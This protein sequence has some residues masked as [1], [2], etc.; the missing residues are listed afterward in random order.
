MIAPLPAPEPVTVV[1]E[2]EPCNLPDTCVQVEECTQFTDF[3]CKFG[4]ITFNPANANELVF[5]KFY[6][7]SHVCLAKYDI[8]SNTTQTLTQ[9]VRAL[10]GAPFWATDGHIYYN[11]SDKN[12]YRIHPQSKVNELVNLKA[13]DMNPIL[14][15][16]AIYTTRYVLKKPSK[17]FKNTNTGIFH[18]DSVYSSSRSVAA[19]ISGDGILA[20]TDSSSKGYNLNLLK[21]VDT[22]KNVISLTNFRDRYQIELFV[23]DIKWHPDNEQVFFVKGEDLYNI[24]INTKKLTLVK[25][26][27][28][29]SLIKYFAISP[30]GKK[31]VCC[32]ETHVSHKASGTQPCYHEYYY[33][34][35]CMDINGCNERELLRE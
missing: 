27:C 33:Y 3:K 35:G 16:N 5:F 28:I 30:D 12:I 34:L 21:Y 19:A 32:Y 10:D 25:R 18:S 14:N 15:G 1:T 6:D 13:G 9:N 23:S 22:K 7:S 26:T 8:S 20:F 11:G 31:I 24:N 29:N 4:K 2:V 17:Y